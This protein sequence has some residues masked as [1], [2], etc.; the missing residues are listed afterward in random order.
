MVSK[1]TRREMIKLSAGALLSL[2]LWPG[3]LRG[4]EAPASKD[5]TFIA[6]NDLHYTELQ[7]RP[8][9]N[10]VARDMKLSAPKAELCLL[11][12]DLSENGTPEQLAAVRDVFRESKMPFYAVIGN[13]DY[14]TSDDSKA[15]DQLFPNSINYWF[16]YAGWQFVGLD[17]SEGMKATDTVISNRTLDWLDSNLPKL[18][19][20]KPTIIVTHFPLGK[21]VVARPRN[22]DALLQ[23]FLNFNLQAVFCGHFHGF[24]QRQFGHA[25]V[26]TDRCCARL[27]NNHDG[28]PDKGWFVCRAAKGEVTRTFVKFVR[29]AAG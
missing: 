17:S 20:R 28:T 27:R 11:G 15:Y 1:L 25:I 18:N 8:W 24:T 16:E 6:V 26:T 3:R 13:H 12:G 7:C 14:Q 5:F 21:S 10:Q 29:E 22:A 2:G 9:F 23:R 4:G 19:S